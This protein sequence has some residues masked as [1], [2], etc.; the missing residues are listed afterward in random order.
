MSSPTPP[1]CLPTANFWT[2]TEDQILR[3]SVLDQA[4]KETIDWHRV[5]AQ[6]TSRTN[7][8]CRK[9]WVYSLCPTLNKGTWMRKENDLLHGR[10]SPV[11]FKQEIRTILEMQDDI[12]RKAVYA[13]GRRWIE[14]VER[15]FPHRRPNATRS[16]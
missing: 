3:S 1:S 8:D 2:E 6:L 10:L 13:H 5:A 12:L 4:D 14:I 9:R 7:K 16:R 15:Y 11:L